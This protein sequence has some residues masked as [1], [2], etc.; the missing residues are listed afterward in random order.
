MLPY[1]AIVKD[2]FREAIASR[3]LWIV[4]L[5]ITGFLLVLAPLGYSQ[6]VTTTLHDDDI[7]QWGDVAR[8]LS[9]ERKKSPPLERIWSA[10]REE[11]R[12]KIADFKPLKDKP[13]LRDISE[14]KDQVRNVRVALNR[15]LD[16]RT[17]YD[18]KAWSDVR[19]SM[20]G[21]ML[22]GRVDE[23]DNDEVR[24]LNRLLIESAFPGL[25]EPSPSTSI[26]FKYALLGEFGEP[27]PVSKQQLAST[28]R[29]SLPWLVDKGLLS[30][31][32]LVAI[33]VTAPI[34]PQ[35]FDPGSLHL[36]LSKPVWRP[37]LYLS[38]FIGGCAFVLLCA[39]YLFVG[40]YLLL[41]AR[42][43]IWEPRLLWSIP[44][45]AFVFAV[46]YSVAALAGLIW[47]S[48]VVSIL[49][50][51]L[52]WAVCFSVG[53]GKVTFEA[54]LNKFRLEKLV[55]AGD[56]VFALDK[57]NT[58]RIW[59][60]EMRLWKVALISNEMAEL[61]PFLST[62]AELPPMIGPVYDPRSESLVAITI[63]MKNGQQLVASGKRSENWKHVEGPAAPLSSV[64]MLAEPDGSPLVL[65]NYGVQR[66]AEQIHT[67]DPPVKI[68]GFAVPL[69][70]RGPLTEAGPTPPQTWSRPLTAA[71]DA[72]TKHLYVYSN[73]VL[74]RLERTS[75]NRYAV[76]A[77]ETIISDG[78]RRIH[79]A[80]AGNVVV[81]TKRDGSVKLY[82]GTSLKER[83]EFIPEPRIRPE[84][85]AGSPDGKYAALLNRSGQLWLLDVATDK[86][87]QPTQIRGQEDISAIAFTP[88]SKLLVCDRTNR[89]LEYELPSFKIGRQFAPPVDLQQ[90]SYRY[91][92][93]PVYTL[94]PKPGEFYKTVEHV[95]KKAEK[96]DAQ[97]RPKRVGE[98]DEPS[99]WAPVWS[100]AAFMAVMLALGCLYMQW[101]EF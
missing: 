19:L 87:S 94:F 36:L 60:P 18:K 7:E 89:V 95:L 83:G 54:Y 85:V 52:F 78:E 91:V 70:T 77:K 56:E 64:A 100:S 88:E 30:F 72:S 90:L 31:G 5:L 23:I 66:V 35:T 20:E 73:G 40:L 92:M 3:V 44:I 43:G 15:L 57:A 22:V 6:L 33:L 16:D 101:Q 46:Y 42:F 75:G 10:M 76:R 63:S 61:Q 17:L 55:P 48:A 37:L 8:L 98:A 32:L 13:S 96:K 62:I 28:L 27:W 80:A 2:S 45:Y 34:I 51:F 21:R 47:R 24:R 14:Y 49:V 38:K 68:L 50:A 12:Q 79:L 9:T 84:M 86:W 81:V 11:D 65:T 71:I 99:P 39:T 1:L 97:P 67:E 69:Q 74:Q 93:L 25:I 4:L 82:D 29:S 41:G 58:P 59:D 53:L 26:R